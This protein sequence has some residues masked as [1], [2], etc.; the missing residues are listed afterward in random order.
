MN[1]KLWSRQIDAIVRLELKRYV[2]GRRWIGVYLLAAAPVLLFLVR[3]STATLRPGRSGE[4]I[5]LLSTIYAGFF[6]LFILRFAIFLSCALIFSQLFR[7]EILEKTLHYYL[8][9][10]VRREILALGKFVAG[11]VGSLTVFG[12]CTIATYVL[13]FYPSPSGASFLWGGPGIS[14]LAR[15]LAVTM[16]ACVGYGSVFVLVGLFVRNPAIPAAALL[17]WESFNFLLPSLLQKLSVV[18][19]LQPLL[20]VSI[21]RG[22]LAIITEPASPLFSIPGLL[23]VTCSILVLAG[24]RVRKLEI[25]YSA[26]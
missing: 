3:A 9:A 16:L 22:P 10:P 12:S 25:T 19:Y 17:A 20:P 21:D 13:L 7:G 4:S 8:L 26:D 1:W 15:Y 11:V 2:L 6:Q 24:R 18:H 23:I 5:E 14:H